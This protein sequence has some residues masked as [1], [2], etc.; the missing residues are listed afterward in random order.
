IWLLK[1]RTKE[2]KRLGEIESTPKRFGAFPQ[3]LVL[4]QD[5]KNAIVLVDGRFSKVDLA[6]A[7]IEPIKFDAEK[8]IDS[9]AERSY[10][11]EHIWRQIKEKLG[12][13]MHDELV[14][15][16][17]GRKYF[18]WVPRGQVLGW[19]PGRKRYK[20]T[21][22]LLNEGNYSD[23]LIFPWS[24]K[25]FQLGKLVGMPVADSG[26]FVWWETLQDPSL[27]F[28]IPEVGLQDEQGQFLE[29]TQ[30]DPDIEVINDPQSTAEGRDL[31]LERAVAELM[32]EN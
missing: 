22:L 13:N 21:A 16:L 4:D 31:Q 27:V 2:L 11:F 7:K 30:V 19:E 28:G 26:S 23:G 15:F 10:L 25:H 17:S 8:E 12:G 18:K 3:Q 32:S 14:T 24:Y 29:R 6:T 1:P 20:K 9:A 5:D